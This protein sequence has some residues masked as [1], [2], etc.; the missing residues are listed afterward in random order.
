MDSTYPKQST[1]G[2]D[3]KTNNIKLIDNGDGTHSISVGANSDNPLLTKI[4]DFAKRSPFV[5]VFGEQIVGTRQN[6]INIPFIRN[7]GNIGSTDFLKTTSF[8]ASGTGTQDHE[9]ETAYL[10]SG[11]GVG[12]AVLK[13]KS[14]N[15]YI[16]GHGNEVFHTMVFDGSE[17]GVDS[18][19]GYGDKDTDF[20]GFGYNGLIF[21]IWQV[22][23]GV[24]VHIPQSSWNENTLETIEDGM[25][26]D[27][28]KEN[29]MGTS[30]GWL[31]VADILY[32]VNAS[33]KDWIL[34]HRHKTANI[35]NKPHLTD[36]TRSIS[37][38]IERISGSGA[39]IRVGTSSWYAGT[40][41]NRAT[42][43]GADKTPLVERDAVVVGS[44][45]KVLIS[46][47]NKLDFAGKPNTVR[48]RYGTLTITSDGTKSVKFKVYLNGVTGGTWADYDTNLSVTELSTT[49]TL[50]LTTVAIDG[51]TKINEQIGSTV[52]GRVDRDRINLFDS[53]IVISANAGDTITITGQSQN[54]SDVDIQL[55]WIEEF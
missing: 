22:L 28:Q 2:S 54:N 15:R 36:P 25:V 9:N 39:T 7:N 30:F 23:R 37:E 42:G 31:G 35:D 20:I 4:T 11:S 48:I 44:T 27:P 29:I 49:T 38:W 8:L 34:V 50:N 1:L 16:T 17:S 21:G 45:E 52:L 6:N 5:T 46:L 47:R 32:Y 43:T 18:G 51:I 19:V 26:L 13:S 53:D 10:Q 40:V 12:T 3:Q 33:D 14:T 24:R 55:R 41:G